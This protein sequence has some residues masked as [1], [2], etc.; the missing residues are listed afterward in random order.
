MLI[1]G[2][3]VALVGLG[4]LLS[5]HKEIGGLLTLLGLAVEIGGA[6]VHDRGHRRRG[7]Q[8]H[9]LWGP[10]DRHRPARLPRRR[11]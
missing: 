7:E 2:T 3:A 10:G 8:P 4:L 5:G 6:W 9:A 11:P 1:G